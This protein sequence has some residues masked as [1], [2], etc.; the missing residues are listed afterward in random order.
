MYAHI[1]LNLVQFF[2]FGEK[3]VSLGSRVSVYLKVLDL[4]SLRS[5]SESRV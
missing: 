5:P 3:T 2:A 4:G 1:D